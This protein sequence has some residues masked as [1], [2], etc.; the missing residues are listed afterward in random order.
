[1]DC[2]RN[3]SW[4]RV[5]LLAWS[6]SCISCIF[7]AVLIIAEQLL[8]WF[9][10]KEICMMCIVHSSFLLCK[11]IHNLWWLHCLVLHVLV[12]N[13]T[14][15]MTWMLRM[16]RKPR[17]WKSWCGT[18]QQKTDGWSKNFKTRNFKWKRVCLPRRFFASIGF[19][20]CA[21]EAFL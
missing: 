12:S 17:S 16:T 20:G 13:R 11:D 2:M 18:L 10:A 8:S 3:M 19:L 7:F 4:A 14:L 6:R 21:L 9:Y 5:T 1:M 15:R